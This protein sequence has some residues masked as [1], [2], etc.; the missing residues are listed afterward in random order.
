MSRSSSRRIPDIGPISAERPASPDEVKVEVGVSAEAPAQPVPLRPDF[1]EN[2]RDTTAE[3]AQQP[4]VARKRDHLTPIPAGEPQRPARPPIPVRPLPRPPAE[5]PG[6]R[7]ARADKDRQKKQR[8]TGQ[9]SRSTRRR[10]RLSK[11][12]LRVLAINVLA[13]AILV[14][15]LL[16]LGQYEERLI[17][18][19]LDNLRVEAQIFGGALAESAIDRNPDAL[20]QVLIPERTRPM[21]RRLNESTESRTRVFDA[22]GVLVADSRSLGG[23]GGLIEIELLPPPTEQSWLRVAFDEVYNWFTGLAPAGKRWPAYQERPDQSAFDYPAVSRALLGDIGR[24]IWTLPD[25]GLILGVAV[26]VQ[27]LREVVGSVLVT[28]DAVGIERA[29]QSVR[30]SILIVFVVG[31]AVTVLLS[32]Y[33]AG[34]ITRPIRRLASAAEDVRRGHG[35]EAEIPDFTRRKDEIGDLSGSLRAMTDALWARMDAIERF[36]ADVAHEIKNP[37]TSLRSAVETTAR[38]KDPEQQRR[39]MAIIL[40]DVQRLDRLITDISNASRLDAELSRAEIEPVNVASMFQMLADLYRPALQEKDL[41]LDV[42]IEDKA[43]QVAGLESRLVQVFRNLIGNAISFSPQNGTIT[44]A[45]RPIRL[46]GR[47]LAEMEV[48]DEGPG[49]QPGKEEAVFDRFY[50]E[51]PSTEKFGTHS[52]LGLSISKQIA[53]AHKGEIFVRNRADRSGCRFTVRIP[54]L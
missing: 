36:A 45:A 24:Q 54:A 38:I 18:S 6:R 8:A 22:Q 28:R 50:T 43:L 31:L 47:L 44:L 40:E 35:R 10:R 30:E 53:E 21:V 16:Y 46:R 39:L 32:L 4:P 12:T 25:G 33:L 5:P 49:V 19:E 14:A 2:T 42:S 15:G 7:K 20:N 9:R 23:P 48:T 3:Q 29:I 34:T 37:L 1:Q 13:L 51:R 41:K 26:P 27:N 11:L 52:G 17:Q